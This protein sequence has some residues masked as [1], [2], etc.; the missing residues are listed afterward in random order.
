MLSSIK[1][2]VFIYLIKVIDTDI[3]FVVMA[4]KQSCAS[5]TEITTVERCKK[6]RKYASYLINDVLKKNDFM[7]PPHLKKGAP[8]QCSI[9]GDK[10]SKNYGRVVF[11]D[12]IYTTNEY[13]S[14]GMI[15]MLCEAGKNIFDPSLTFKY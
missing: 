4:A 7:S 6:T 8:L 10:N 14:N 2:Y 9:R 12:Y 5:G 11:N 15:R 1:L 13:F 3:P